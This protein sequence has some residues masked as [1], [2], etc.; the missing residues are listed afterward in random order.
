MTLDQS[1][2]QAIL[3]NSRNALRQGDL[4]A[5]SSWA[6]QA[7][8]LAPDQEDP[9]LILAAVADPRASIVY[10]NRALDINPKSERARK[11]MQWAVQRYRKSQII[12]YPDPTLRVQYPIPAE[13]FFRRKAVVYP[14]LLLIL[15]SCFLVG[16]GFGYPTIA[17]AFAN[18]KPAIM[19]QLLRPV[20]QT[21]TLATSETALPL[22]ASTV[23]YRPTASAT[24]TLEA[25]ATQPYLETPI[26][27][28]TPFPTETATLLSTDVPLPATDV[29]IP[30]TDNPPPATDIPPPPTDI[31]PPATDIPTDLPAPTL[32]PNGKFEL[33]QVDPGE[34]WIDVDLSQ[35]RAY[36][37]EGREIVNTFVVSTGLPR[38]PTVTGQFHIYVKYR[39]ADMTGPGYN[40]PDVPYVMYFYKDYGLHGTYWHKNFG[41]PMSHGCVNFKTRDARWLF[42]WASV[43]TLV[44]VH[45]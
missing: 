40:L 37:F 12:H 36:A 18:N 26:D 41:H 2:Y 19:S 17:A 3:Q 35:Q 44:N 20:T 23:F 27:T 11:G 1:R 30:A 5:A 22:I 33:P 28:D 9:W 31:P 45:R 16:V 14:W 4:A 21:S 6:Q 13:A 42:E 15:I 38:T 10:L 7:A 39:A 34:R 25:T 8:V 24:N 29:P 43:G 32:G